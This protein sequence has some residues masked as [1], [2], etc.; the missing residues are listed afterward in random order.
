MISR[1]FLVFFIGY[2]FF[3]CS[4]V[5]LY[6]S[7]GYCLSPKSFVKMLSNHC[8]SFHCRQSCIYQQKKK[9][10]F[11]SFPLFL[12]FPPYVFATSVFFVLFLFVFHFLLNQIVFKAVTETE[13]GAHF[14]SDDNNVYISLQ[15]LVCES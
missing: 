11:S 13:V 7:I 4:F 12:L 9:T 15:F 3:C 8:I 14:N 2:S 1:C 10:M 6:S 5:N